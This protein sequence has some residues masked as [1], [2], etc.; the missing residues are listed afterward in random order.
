MVGRRVD[1]SPGL[2]LV[3][4]GVL[5]EPLR[6]IGVLDD[7][8]LIDLPVAVL[9]HQRVELVLDDAELKIDISATPTEQGPASKRIAIELR[10]KDRSGRALAPARAHPTPDV[11][12]AWP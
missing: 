4:G 11:G 5:R 9:F 2:L 7:L 12:P 8:L 1:P 10:W 6:Q 3:G